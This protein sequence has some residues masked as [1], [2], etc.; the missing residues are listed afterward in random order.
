MVAKLHI[1]YFA[2]VREQI[3]TGQESIDHPGEGVR[4]ADL[5]ATLGAR[6]GGYAEALGNPGKLRAAIDQRFVPL[7]APLGQARELAIFPPVTGG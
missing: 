1:L 3:G 2:W 7:E 6:G 5:I 4:I